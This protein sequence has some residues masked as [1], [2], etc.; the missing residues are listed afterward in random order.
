MA[1]SDNSELCT[2]LTDE[3]APSEESSVE[4]QAA[5]VVPES[6]PIDLTGENVLKFSELTAFRSESYQG[7]VPHPDHA[8]AYEKLVP[9]SAGRF[10][11]MAE[12]EQD[13]RHAITVKGQDAEIE[14]VLKEQE[15][16]GEMDRNAFAALKRGQLF[17]LFAIAGGLGTAIVA[18]HN[19]QP[20]VAAVFGVLPPLVMAFVSLIPTIQGR[21][22][23]K[24]Q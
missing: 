12:K 2:S 4:M 20:W 6:T 24:E 21:S 13:H 9:G 11:A 10:L 17:G 22:S 8:A 1:E 23:K 18:S 15:L 19:N 16:R 14:V 3:R 7:P 5:E